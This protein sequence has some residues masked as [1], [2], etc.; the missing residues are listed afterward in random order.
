[1]LGMPAQQAANPD[2][3]HNPHTL[4]YFVALGARL[5]AHGDAKQPGD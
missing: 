4:A 2:S 1:L 3:M 5:N